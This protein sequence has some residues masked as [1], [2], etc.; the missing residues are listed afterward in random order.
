VSVRR[1]FAIASPVALSRGRQAVLTALRR[2]AIRIE[3]R[4]ADRARRDSARQQT[5]LPDAATAA[6]IVSQTERAPTGA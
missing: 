1:W 6:E 5:L 2:T 3:V 4:E